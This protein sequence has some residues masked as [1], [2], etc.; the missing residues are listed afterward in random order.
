MY[1]FEYIRPA[2]LTEALDVLRADVEP[3]LLAGGQTL[4]P[5]LKH[6]LSA[7]STLIDLQ[8]IDALHGIR[9]GSDAIVLGAMTRHADVADHPEIGSALPALAQLAGG[10]GDP[11][12]RNMGTIG[13]SIANN[14]PAA[15]YPA[16]ILGLNATVTTDRR[17]IAADE[18]FDG[19]FSTALEEDEI[20]TSITFPVPRRAGYFKLPHPASG[21]VM[22]GAFVAEFDGAV[23]C[24]VNGMEPCVFRETGIEAQFSEGL[25][26]RETPAIERG[27]DDFNDDLF[28]SSDYRARVLPKVIERAIANALQTH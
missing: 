5:T 6:R 16:A 9:V 13:G 8:G 25:A 4:L 17:D 11:L 22:A 27:S 23:R 7:H 3:R 28:A 2:T 24:A 10:I 20:I 26:E 19:M 21:Y 15:D 14:D 12:V 1:G 18:F